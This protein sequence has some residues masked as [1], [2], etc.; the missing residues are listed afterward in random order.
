MT[1]AGIS[2]IVKHR[3]ETAGIGLVHAHRLHHTFATKH[4]IAA[5]MHVHDPARTLSL[6]STRLGHSSPEHT[7]WHLSAAPELLTAAEHRLEPAGV[8]GPPS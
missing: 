8:E 5:Y 2:D 4:M 3:A 7:Y 1:R 6:L